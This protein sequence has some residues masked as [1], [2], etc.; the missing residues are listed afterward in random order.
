M[1]VEVSTGVFFH[2]S[3]PSLLRQAFSLQLRLT[4]LGGIDWTM[5][6]RDLPIPAHHPTV[7]A[8]RL[9]FFGGAADPHQVLI[10]VPQVLY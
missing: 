8:T 2:H 3:P 4:D 6:S 5:S 10:P 7:H 1:E 9:S